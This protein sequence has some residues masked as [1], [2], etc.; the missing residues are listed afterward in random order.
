MK[1]LT[2]HILKIFLHIL[3]YA[4]IF[5]KCEQQMEKTQ[6]GFRSN[7]GTCEAIFIL[8]MITQRYR[9][10]NHNVYAIFFLW[11]FETHSAA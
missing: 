10:T 7:L 3:L 6:F 2:S 8:N 5:R 9:D 4:R 11:T 1:S